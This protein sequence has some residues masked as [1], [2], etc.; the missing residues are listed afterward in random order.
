MV[1]YKKKLK[2]LVPADRGDGVRIGHQWMKIKKDV[3]IYKLNHFFFFSHLFNIHSLSYYR[4]QYMVVEGSSEG[5][6]W[7]SNQVSFG[8]NCV[9]WQKRGWLRVLEGEFGWLFVK[10]QMEP[11]AC[12]RQSWASLYTQEQGRHTP[13]SRAKHLNHERLWLGKAT[14]DLFRHFR[15]YSAA[16]HLDAAISQKE[17]ALIVVPRK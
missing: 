14:I 15:S 8:I 1:C 4:S 2:K 16:D 6:I 13:R 5:L 11:L 12:M 7:H 10:N 9:V 3:A 17:K